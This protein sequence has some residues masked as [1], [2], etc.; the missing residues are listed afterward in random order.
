MAVHELKTHPEP[1][2]AVVHGLKPWE[3][4]FNDRNFQVGDTVVL[5]EFAPYSQ[6]YTGSH[7]TKRVGYMLKGP[8]FNIPEGFV[9]FTLEETQ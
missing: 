1:F 2:Q 7:I 6:V 9:V 4:R 5:R 3:I 8:D